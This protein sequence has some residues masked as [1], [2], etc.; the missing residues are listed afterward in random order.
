MTTFEVHSAAESTCVRI[1]NPV[2]RHAHNISD[3]AHERR[4]L[5]GKQGSEL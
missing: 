3:F 2:L 1:D 5:H 4:N